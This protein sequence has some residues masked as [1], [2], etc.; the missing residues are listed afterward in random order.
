VV[1]VCVLTEDKSMLLRVWDGTKI[2]MYVII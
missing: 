1:A 2:S